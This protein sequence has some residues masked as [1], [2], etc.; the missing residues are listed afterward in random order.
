MLL[1]QIQSCSLAIRP[2]TTGF[3]KPFYKQ[4]PFMHSI[5]EVDTTQK[6]A[7]GKLNKSSCAKRKRNTINGFIAFIDNHMSNLQEKNNIFYY[8]APEKANILIWR[9]QYNMS[10]HGFCFCW[11]CRFIVS[12]GM[13]IRE[14]VS[15]KIV[16]IRGIFDLL[17]K[18]LFKNFQNNFCDHGLNNGWR[19]KNYFPLIKV[20]FA[21]STRS[22]ECRNIPNAF[23]AKYL[24]NM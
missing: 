19:K 5:S 21:Q 14:M 12:I 23:G 2:W 10:E 1:I 20:V 13:L 15:I 3:F 4:F 7:S 11:R 18:L 6:K 17:W 16:E 8:A 9:E 22:I 24:S